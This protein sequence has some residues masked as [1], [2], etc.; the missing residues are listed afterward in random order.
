M[1]YRI[2]E[3]LRESAE[4]NCYLL[5]IAKLED[6][7]KRLHNENLE[8]FGLYLFLRMHRNRIIDNGS[9]CIQRQVFDRS[10]ERRVE[11]EHCCY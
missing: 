5:S 9:T 4:R 1:I 3:I 11:R 2:L 6:D 7:Y 10:V 8:V